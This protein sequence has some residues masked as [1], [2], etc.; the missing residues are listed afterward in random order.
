MLV[1]AVF[2]ALRNNNPVK[3]DL[4]YRQANAPKNRA[5]EP[6]QNLDLILKTQQ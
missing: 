6:S 3:T 5:S 2:I 4:N 1:A